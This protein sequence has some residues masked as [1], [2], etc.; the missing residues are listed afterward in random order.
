MVGY[1]LSKRRIFI[2]AKN[3]WNPKSPSYVS[4]YRL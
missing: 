4:A 3:A 1:T 2:E